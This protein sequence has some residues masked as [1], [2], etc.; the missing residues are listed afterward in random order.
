MAVL[1]VGVMVQGA[2]SQ[3]STPANGLGIPPAATVMEGTPT[4]RVDSSEGVTTRR[5]LDPAEA[6]KSRLQVS[7][8]DGQYYWTSRE[9][10]P[11]RLA[12][13]GDFTY[14][15]SEPGRYIRFT[16]IK[17]RIAYVEHVD[18]AL[19]SVTWWGELKIVTGAQP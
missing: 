14:L 13:A 1:F 9:N 11:L 17:D 3:E 2:L 5:L 4:V 12:S 10:Q 8:V 19:G 7:V 18:V 16:R 15:S 6:A